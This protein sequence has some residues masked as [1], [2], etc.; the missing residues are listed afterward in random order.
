MI[1]L[2]QDLGD[3][4]RRN[5]IFQDVVD[6]LDVKRL[7]DLGVRRDKQVQINQDWDGHEQQQED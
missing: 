3:I 2:S 5:A 7:L 6:G 1:I 4:F